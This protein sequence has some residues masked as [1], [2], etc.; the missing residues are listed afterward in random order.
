[1]PT[2]THTRLA[3]KKFEKSIGSQG[4][5]AEEREQKRKQSE[6]AKNQKTFSPWL[7]GFLIVV[8]CGSFFVQIITTILY[9]PS[10]SV[11]Q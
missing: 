9:S 7:I 2:I 8:V 10:M 4:L 6:E 1:M 11:A 5:S 3:Q